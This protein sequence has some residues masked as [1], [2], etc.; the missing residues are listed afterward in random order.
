MFVRSCVRWHKQHDP[1]GVWVHC[2]HVM[3]VYASARALACKTAR[4]GNITAPLSDW[5]MDY[6]NYSCNPVM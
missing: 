3:A 5:G 2:H 6:S 4:Y 1:L